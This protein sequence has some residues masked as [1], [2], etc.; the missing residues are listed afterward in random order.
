MKAKRSLV[1]LLC[2]AMLACTV[3]QI[4]TDLNLLV[5][6]A[7]AIIP[8]IGNVSPDDAA[9]A[10][11]ISNIA[12]TGIAAVQAA[13]K[14]YKASGAATDLAKVQAAITAVKDNLAQELAAAHVSNPAVVAKITVWV[15]LISTT[16]NAI[17]SALPQPGV[18]GARPG[19][20]PAPAEVKARW[21]MEVCGGDAACAA[22]VK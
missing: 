14:D 2:I 17:L 20:V 4:L 22:L 16:L 1:W 9:I 5:N 7:G 3:G 13:Y 10:Q 15:N 12:S 8:A 6:I 21:Q 18:V 19:P 11:K